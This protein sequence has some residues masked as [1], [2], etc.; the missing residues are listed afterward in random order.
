MFCVAPRALFRSNFRHVS[1]SVLH[2]C[3]VV[4]VWRKRSVALQP[5]V[6]S[7]GVCLSMP[8][9]PGARFVVLALFLAAAQVAHWSVVW[10]GWVVRCGFVLSAIRCVSCADCCCFSASSRWSLRCTYLVC[11]NTFVVARHELDMIYLVGSILLSLLNG[12]GMMDGTSHC[13]FKC[14]RE[15]SCCYRSAR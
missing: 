1:P 3:A 15:G 8:D 5:Y 4:R 11:E 14:F 7:V 13:A 2:C 9:V 10:L 12:E 6:P